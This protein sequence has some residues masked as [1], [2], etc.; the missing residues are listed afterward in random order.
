MDHA[1]SE[2]K[3]TSIDGLLCGAVFCRHCCDV[4][5][6]QT[7]KVPKAKDTFFGCRSNS[8]PSSVEHETH[9]SNRCRS[10]SSSW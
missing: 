5:G 3:S 4:E 7:Q 2:D 10:Y 6:A 9:E 1:T 8:N